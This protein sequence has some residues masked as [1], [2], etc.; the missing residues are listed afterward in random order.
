MADIGRSEVEIFM[1]EQIK[2]KGQFYSDG[3]LR[4]R[5][6]LAKCSEFEKFA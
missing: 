5:R 1:K 4:K 6:H 3:T 2:T